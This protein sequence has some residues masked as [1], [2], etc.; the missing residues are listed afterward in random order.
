MASKEITAPCFVS[1]SRD[2]TGRNHH[3]VDHYYHMYDAPIL[4]L[5]IAVYVVVCDWTEAL[6]VYEKYCFHICH[7]AWCHFFV[8]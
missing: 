2:I 1:V 6:E 7:K 8:F 4:S 3:Y 5:T